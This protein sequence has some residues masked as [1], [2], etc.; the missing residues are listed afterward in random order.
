MLPGRSFTED[1]FPIDRGW[2]GGVGVWFRF[3]PLLTSCCAARF[4]TGHGPVLVLGPG[5]EDPWSRTYPD[6]QFYQQNE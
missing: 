5:G 6:K 1:N 2:A 3:H 4:L